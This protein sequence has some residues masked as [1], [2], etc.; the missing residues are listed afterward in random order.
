MLPN[1]E[2]ACK[3]LTV[4]VD[5]PDM[6]SRAAMLTKL[7]WY[8]GRPCSRQKPTQAAAGNRE[9]GWRAERETLELSMMPADVTAIVKNN[10]HNMTYRTYG[11]AHPMDPKGS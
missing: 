3:L 2:R 10:F 4:N 5:D 7:K 11:Q 8:F 9:Q 6:S 1:H